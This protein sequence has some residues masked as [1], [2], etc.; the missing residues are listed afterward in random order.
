[1]REPTCHSL[2]VLKKIITWWSAMAKTAMVVMVR[3]LWSC[4]GV[5]HHFSALSQKYLLCLGI[6]PLP[7]LAQQF[8]SKDVK[9][10]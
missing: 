9:P 5:A 8:N 10:L 3:W 7:L 2:E 6:T 4:P 1:M